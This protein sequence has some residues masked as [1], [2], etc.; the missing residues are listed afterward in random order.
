[1]TEVIVDLRATDD[2]PPCPPV[3]RR[4]TDRDEVRRA[5]DR[6]LDDA[7]SWAHE[8]QPALAA[9]VN[10]VAV[11]L[12]RSQNALVEHRRRYYRVAA[13]TAWRRYVG[14]VEALLAD[15]AWS[16]T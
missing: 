2:G 15:P 10:E 7:A 9:Q 13:Q 8:E 5:I 4:W 6:L 14:A 1:V 12:M 3:I 16:D 11:L